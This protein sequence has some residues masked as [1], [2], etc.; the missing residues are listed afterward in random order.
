MK[1]LFA[2]LIVLLLSGIAGAKA[3]DKKQPSNAEMQDVMK[4][5]MEAATPNEHHKALDGM[6]GK[7]NMETTTWMDPGAP[8]MKTKG[9]AEI[10]WMIDGRFL[11]Q[12]AKGEFMGGPFIGFGLTG[13]DNNKKC[14]TMLWIDN[15]TTA[16]SA[17]EGN[18]NESGKIMTMYGKMDEPTTGEHDK[19]VKYV[20]KIIDKDSFLFEVHDL[21]LDEPHTKTMEIA[22]TRAK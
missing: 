1:N 5:W 12:D 10:S 11:K 21:S 7:W 4:K 14:Y 2:I 22:Y 3:Q 16:M 6:V 17:A 19:N 13:Y 9:T 15:T 18:F 20:L 8:P